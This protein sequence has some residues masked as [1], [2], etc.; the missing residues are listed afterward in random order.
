M[1]LAV[2]QKVELIIRAVFDSPSSSC[3]GVQANSGILYPMDDG[4]C[5]LEKVSA[6]CK[7]CDSGIESA[8][9]FHHAQASMSSENLGQFWLQT[10]I[11]EQ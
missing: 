3:A 9:A 2:N 11:S 10:G 4:F 8:Q 6:D 1:L 5:F 7:S